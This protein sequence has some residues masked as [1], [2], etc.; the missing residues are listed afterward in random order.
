MSWFWLFSSANSFAQANK[1][2]AKA[3][4]GKSRNISSIKPSG[5][6]NFVG[7]GIEMIVVGECVRVVTN[8]GVDS[9]VDSVHKKWWWCGGL[10]I[11]V[12]VMACGVCGNVSRGALKNRIYLEVLMLPGEGE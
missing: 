11:L 6:W 2:W 1:I 8:G 7:G 12:G 5:N 3:Q 10:K 9:W 4:I